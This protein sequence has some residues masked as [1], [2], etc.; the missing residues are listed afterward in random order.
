MTNYATKVQVDRGQLVLA[1]AVLKKAQEVAEA[2][3]APPAL[4]MSKFALKAYNRFTRD[5]EVGGP[6]V[7]NFLLGQ[8]SAYTPRSDASVTI[9]FHWVKVSLALL[10][11]RDQLRN[12]NRRA[13]RL[14]ADLLYM[15][16]M[17]IVAQDS[18]ICVSMNTYLR[19]LFRP[20]KARAIEYFAFHLILLIRYIPLI[21]R[22][23][24]VL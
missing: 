10:V 2:A 6:A 8:P 16:T 13:V 14:P 3:A 4:D 11:R 23:L 22:S 19:S 15:R 18:L 17:T 24:W 1:A 9:N 7:A 12:G 5:T 20:S 21:S